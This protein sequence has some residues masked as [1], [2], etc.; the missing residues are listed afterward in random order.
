[1]RPILQFLIFEILII[2]FWGGGWQKGILHIIKKINGTA[3]YDRV[4]N[5]RCRLISLCDIEGGMWDGSYSPSHGWGP[6]VCTGV[7]PLTA[8]S[9]SPNYNYQFIKERL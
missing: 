6:V 8:P 3:L 1:M 2:F 4:A 7:R 5:G 9:V